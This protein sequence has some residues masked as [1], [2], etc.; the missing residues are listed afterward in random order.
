MDSNPDTIHLSVSSVSRTSSERSFL[1]TRDYVMSSLGEPTQ[2][3]P[4]KI[5]CPEITRDIIEELGPVF[6]D[7]EKEM[8]SGWDMKERNKKE[9]KIKVLEGVAHG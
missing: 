1:E 6:E 8:V 9:M 4:F 7:Y 5:I 2:F 3:L